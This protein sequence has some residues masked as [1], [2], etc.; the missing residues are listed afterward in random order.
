MGLAQEVND[1]TQLLVRDSVA[2][3]TP[4]EPPQSIGME[5]QRV[6]LTAPVVDMDTLAVKV[7]PS[8]A[9]Y[10]PDPNRVIWMGALIPGYGQIVNKKYW[11]LPFVYGGFMGMGYVVNWNHSRYIDYKTGYID[12]TDNDDS[13]NYYLNLL[14]RG[15]TIEN[16][17]GGKS[18]FTARLKSSMDRFRH[19]RDLS[20]IVSAGVYALVLLDAFVDAQL[21]DFDISDDLVLNVAPARI[22]YNQGKNPAFGLQFNI[23]F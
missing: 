15:Y 1:T 4:V 9:D 23:K 2:E 8:R 21:Y 3:I 5:E 22:D 7:K 14:P 6:P 13:T 10:R 18:T 17:P 12:I 19:Y 11:K 20:I 16:F